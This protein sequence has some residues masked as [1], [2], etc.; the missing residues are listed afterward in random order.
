MTHGITYLPRVD[1]IVVISKGTISE[2]GTYKELLERKGDFA[3]FLMTY[4]GNEDDQD[5]DI[6]GL[7]P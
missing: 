4:L 3:E 6:E 7:S 1:L 5:V 2:V